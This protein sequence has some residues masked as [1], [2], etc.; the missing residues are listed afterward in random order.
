MRRSASALV[1]ALGLAALFFTLF[2]LF[3]RYLPTVAM[4]EVKTML[5][6]AHAHG[7][8]DPD[9]HRTD[10]RPDEHHNPDK[11]APRLANR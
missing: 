10:Y 4:A 1:L 3:C 6:E 8:H 9:S 7:G 5:P 11:D 2:C